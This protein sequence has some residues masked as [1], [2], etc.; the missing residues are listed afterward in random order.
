[1]G[2]SAKK[3]FRLTSY[4]INSRPGRVKELRSLLRSSPRTSGRGLKKMGQAVYSGMIFH[5][6]YNYMGTIDLAENLGQ[7]KQSICFMAGFRV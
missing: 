2:F 6:D 5:R 4:I 1:M 3:Q 7:Q